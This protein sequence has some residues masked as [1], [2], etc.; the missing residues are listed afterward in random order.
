MVAASVRSVRRRRARTWRDEEVGRGRLREVVVGAGVEAEDLVALV[1]AGGEHEDG[2][3]A[4]V[5]VL[6]QALARLEPVHLRHHDVEHD[7]VGPLGA[8][9]AEALGA[10]LRGQHVEALAPE[11]VREQ[12]QQVLF[13]VDEED[14]AGGEVERGI[15]HGGGS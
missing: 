2:R 10:V 15:G 8:G 14:R 12:L 7:D 6:A 3:E 11:R 9:E 5:R 13:V 4:E 1:A